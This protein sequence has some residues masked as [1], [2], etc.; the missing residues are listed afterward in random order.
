MENISNDHIA[1]CEQGTVV[2]YRRYRS[3]VTVY[4]S[5]PRIIKLLLEKA[6]LSKNYAIGNVKKQHGEIVSLSAACPKKIMV[7]LADA[8]GWKYSD[9]KPQGRGREDSRRRDHHARNNA[10][11]RKGVKAHESHQH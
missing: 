8:L 7:Y 10:G 3:G 4:T 2:E 9:G 6:A 11:M 5:N 1:I